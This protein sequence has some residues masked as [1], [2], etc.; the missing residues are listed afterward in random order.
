LGLKRVE[1]T[2]LNKF[3]KQKKENPQEFLWEESV[4]LILKQVAQALDFVH[5][6]GLIHRDL[7]PS[8]LIYDPSSG[9]VTLLDFGLAIRADKDNMGEECGTT[10]YEAPEQIS[11]SENKYTKAVDI[12]AVG[13]IMYEMLTLGEHPISRKDERKR[14]RSRERYR[15]TL[16]QI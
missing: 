9:H 6:S 1:G 13:I 5:Q 14:S 4:S 7:K 16:E 10:V 3:I 2:P 11:R 12:W 8:N 15:E